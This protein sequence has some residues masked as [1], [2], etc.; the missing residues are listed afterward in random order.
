MVEHPESAREAAP[1]AMPSGCSNLLGTTKL[2]RRGGIIN[3]FLSDI[4]L[5]GE[6]FYF[7]QLP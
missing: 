1:Q 7:E 5:I 6:A 4:Y 3:N 2:T